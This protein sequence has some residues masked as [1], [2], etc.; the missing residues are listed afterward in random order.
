MLLL[1]MGLVEGRDEEVR[2]EEVR[3]EVKLVVD[4]LS[5]DVLLRELRTTVTLDG[6]TS[7]K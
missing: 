4:S 7:K 5:T 2:V 1:C 3:V 6:R